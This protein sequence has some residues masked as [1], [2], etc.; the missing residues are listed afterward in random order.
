[1]RVTTTIP[2]SAGLGSSAAYSVGVAGALLIL[3]TLSLREFA[4]EGEMMSH[5]ES[6]FPGFTLKQSENWFDPKKQMML[7]CDILFLFSVSLPNKEWI[8]AL[9]EWAHLAEGILHGKASGIDNTISSFGG[10]M[11]ILVECS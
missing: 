10:L 6:L 4:F 9:N 1:M 2:I 8:V 11:M 7:F 3:R 5:L